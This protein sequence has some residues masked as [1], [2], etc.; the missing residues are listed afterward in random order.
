MMAGVPGQYVLFTPEGKGIFGELDANGIVTFVVEAGPGSSVRGT[1]LF[2]RMILHFGNAAVAIHGVWRKGRLGLPS[3][4]I[5]KVNELTSNAVPL[6]DAL[7]HAWTVTR[8]KKL[9]FTRV[10]LLGQPVGT[11]GAYLEIDVLIEK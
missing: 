10:Q 5:D 3:T 11:P 4:N 7:Q 8:A 6:E 2:N 1:E 9:G